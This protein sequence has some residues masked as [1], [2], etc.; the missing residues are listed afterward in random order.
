MRLALLH[1]N[2]IHGRC[3]PSTNDPTKAKP[4]PRLGEGFYHIGAE[5]R[6]TLKPVR[7]PQLRC[8]TLLLL[9]YRC[10]GPAPIGI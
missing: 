4:S 1:I 8:F 10:G 9:R 6:L 5:L 3:K 7:W 2:I